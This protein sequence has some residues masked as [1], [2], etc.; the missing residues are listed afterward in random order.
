MISEP[1]VRRFLVFT[2]RENEFSRHKIKRAEPEIDSDK[3]AKL[4]HTRARGPH[5]F[6]VTGLGRAL[7]DFSVCGPPCLPASS[8]CCHVLPPHA[9]HAARDH[10]YRAAALP[11][12]GRPPRAGLVSASEMKPHES[13]RDIAAELHRRLGCCCCC[14]TICQRLLS[15]EGERTSTPLRHMENAQRLPYALS[16]SLLLPPA[17]SFLPAGPSGRRPSSTSLA[18][19]RAASLCRVPLPVSADAGMS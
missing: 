2:P 16:P 4:S 15:P 11:V 12:V 17:P 5:S 1:G 8:S 3:G 10:P 18:T 13:P 6:A 19:F 14:C 7:P 9:V